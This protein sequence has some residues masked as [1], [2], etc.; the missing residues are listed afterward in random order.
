MRRN[1][2][3]RAVADFKKTLEINPTLQ[4]TRHSMRELGV[5]P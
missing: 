2:I 4:T 5:K 1:E 3:N